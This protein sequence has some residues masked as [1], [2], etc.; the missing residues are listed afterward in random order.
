MGKLEANSTYFCA[1]VSGLPF[2]LNYSN[3][4][5]NGSIYYISYHRVEL[6][7]VAA[8]WTNIQTFLSTIIYS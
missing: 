1:N 2:D 4:S 7:N 6:L 8:K 5:N 3:L